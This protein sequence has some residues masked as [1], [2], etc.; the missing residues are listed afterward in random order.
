MNPRI[1]SQQLLLGNN[2]T[3]RRLARKAMFRVRSRFS[4]YVCVT[5]P[6]G[7]FIVQTSDHGPGET[8]FS[9]GAND[10]YEIL[11]KAVATAQRHDRLGS[12][13]SAITFLEIG[14]N[15]G[16]TTVPA[17]N[18]V[19]FGRATV[20]E[21]AP[22]NLRLLRTNLA[23]NGLLDRVDVLELAVGNEVGT[24]TLWLGSSNLGDHRLWHQDGIGLQDMSGS[25]EVQVRP[26]DNLGIPSQSFGFIWIDTQGFEGFVLSGATETLQT[27]VP[28]VTEFWPSG[29]KSSGSWETYRTVVSSAKFLMNLRT[30]EEFTQVNSAAID[31]LASEYTD[32]HTYADLLMWF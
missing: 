13:L 11:C 30:G 6:Y 17:L 32:I 9:E 14:G 16:T 22:S 29:M 24:M 27:G 7:S 12:D 8:L 26:L 2:A 18:S 3:R 1:V 25:V 4:D 19:G 23:L 28:V 10:D 5:T 15:I 21:P 31:R 20:V